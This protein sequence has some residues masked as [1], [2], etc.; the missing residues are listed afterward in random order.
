MMVLN[1]LA[2]SLGRN[3]EVPN[4]ELAAELA[5]SGNPDAIRELVDNLKNK[6]NAISSDCIKVLYEIGERE[7]SL[8]AAYAGEFT[9]L[10]RSKNNRL[11]WGGMTALGQIAPLV[12]DEM[13]ARIDEIKNATDGGSAITQDWGI[14]VISAIAAS[15]DIRR[16]ELFPYLI[17]FLAECAPKD[18]P[19]HAESAMVAVNA[20]NAGDFLALLRRRASELS[21]AQFGRVKRLERKLGA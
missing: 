6:S 4:Q 8:I 10:L 5:E 3:D 16:H 18:L 14:R 9:N 17:G 7:P 11:V 19:R 15:T 13:Y 12:P 21:P 1:E 2:S 20:G